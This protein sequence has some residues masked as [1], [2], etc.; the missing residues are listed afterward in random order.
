MAEV[1]DFMSNARN[2]HS[3]WGEDGIIEAIL[4]RFSIAPGYFVEFGAWDGKHLSNSAK[5]AEEG[6]RGCFIEGDSARF[7]D[8]LANYGDNDKISKINAMVGWSGEQS[9]DNLLASVNAPIDV[10]VMSIDID[11]YD[12]QVWQG[13]QKYRPKMCIVEFNPTVPAGVSYAQPDG[14]DVVF[15]SSLSAFVDLGKTKGYSLVAATEINGF[16]VLSEL[17]EAAGVAER[18]AEDVK[19]KRFETQIFYGYDGTIVTT[20]LNELVWHGIP[21]KQSDFQLLPKSLRHFPDHQGDSFQKELSD[22]R[23]ERQGVA[24]PQPAEAAKAKGLSRFWK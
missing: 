9:L 19:S 23:A 7:N 6:W 11:G 10:T 16:F 15:G 22:F 17:C 21:F 8:L 13:L 18:R 20:G 1:V 3:Q 2:V 4:D 5:L 12:Y 24:V 14:G